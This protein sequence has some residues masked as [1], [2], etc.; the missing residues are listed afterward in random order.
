[1]LKGADGLLNCG[2]FFDPTALF[3]TL[4][5]LARQSIVAGESVQLFFDR[6]SRHDYEMMHGYFV[7]RGRWFERFY[8][9]P[10]DQKLAREY[11]AAIN[12]LLDREA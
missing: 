9:K 11:R 10:F 2:P 4:S 6:S 1:M 8:G 12:R 7:L 5:E 3:A